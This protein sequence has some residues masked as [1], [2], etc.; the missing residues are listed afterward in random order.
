MNADGSDQRQLPV[1]MT[2]DYTYGDDQVV[3]WGA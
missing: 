2:I 1:D 3:S